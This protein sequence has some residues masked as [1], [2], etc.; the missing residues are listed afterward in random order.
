[1]DSK[2]FHF[3][4][5][6]SEVVSDE[7][8]GLLD[9]EE[10]NSAVCHVSKLIN[11]AFLLFMGDHFSSSV[12]LSITVFEKIAKIKS[13]HMRSWGEQEK[14]L[15][16]R[17]KDP[18]FNH[19]KKHKIA[20]DPI[21][22]IGKRI[23]KSIGDERAKEFFEKYETGEYSKLREK[24]LYFSRS[25]EGLHIP[26]EEIGLTLS[27]EHLLIAMEIF[28]DEFLGMT[29]KASEVCDTINILYAEVESRLK[30]S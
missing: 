23:S 29:D 12:F 22:L 18:L 28:H 30:S 20:I 17:N 11:A 19:G 9:K 16:K 3:E 21:Y 10:Y 14:P 13:G 1:M 6:A 24:S 5:A 26:S 8:I 4:Y 15:V 25:K 27:A 7:Y 2:G